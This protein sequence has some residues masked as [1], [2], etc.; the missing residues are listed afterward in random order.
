VSK[1]NRPKVRFP[2]F[3]DKW[4]ERRLEDICSVNMGQS[5]SSKNYTENPNDML[6]IQGN[7]DLKKGKV[8]PRI[9]TTEITKKSGPGDIIMT[10]RAPV[11][12]IAQNTYFA[13]IGR[14][15]CAI[16]GDRFIYYLLNHLKQK[17][18]FG[19][20]SQGSTFEAISSTDIKN[21]NIILPSNPEKE[22]ITDFLSKVDEKVDKL[23]KK[24]HLW[25][26]YKNGI[27]KKLFGQELRFKKENGNDYPEWEDRKLGDFVEI[28][29]GQSPN[30]LLKENGTIPYF[31]VDQLNNSD[32]YQSDTPY[33][34]E[35]IGKKVKKGSI[36][37]PKRGAAILLNKVRI[38]NQD[39]FM[40]TNLMTL[41][42]KKDLDNEFLYYFLLIEKLYKIADTSS[43]PQINNKHIT[44][45][46]I[47]IPSLLEQGKIANF[48]SFIDKKIGELNKELELNKEFRKGLLQQMFC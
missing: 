37:F 1:L 48:L 36:I 19:R 42:V 14:G 15:V 47:K 23:D 45:Y 28:N 5:P 3:S 11:G 34:I 21:L 38:L 4:V 46:K 18:V 26:N 6:L 7:A 24:H 39:S 10:V 31:K 13:C 8:I 40:D 12:D 35:N 27:M 17:N 9:Y 44:P 43:I 30:G 25:N 33:F 20:I 22:K 29:S 16:K 2:E 41:M 32:K